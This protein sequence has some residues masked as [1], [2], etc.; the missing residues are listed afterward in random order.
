MKNS[1]AALATGAMILA[2]S[3]FA[4]VAPASADP[5]SYGY[6][7][8]HG[9]YH[10]RYHGR[11]RHHYRGHHGHGAGYA[12]LGLGAGLLLYSAIDSANSR[13]TSVYR[14][15]D[16]R[17]A[18]IY[19]SPGYYGAPSAARQVY[20]ARAPRYAPPPEAVAGAGSQVAS[21]CVQTREY[22]T[23]VVIAGEEREAYGTACLQPDG[24]WVL[25]APQ[26]APE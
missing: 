19:G 8:Y 10:G 11:G 16:S 25:G 26:F 7:G 22:Q 21:S 3:N 4:H 14:G 15:Y 13:R 1:L 2:G 6:G 24:A 20:E 17:D 9:G 18:I 5:Q 23:T 12:L